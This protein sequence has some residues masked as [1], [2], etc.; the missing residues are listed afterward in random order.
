MKQHSTKII[1]III[2][3]AIIYLVCG[4]TYAVVRVLVQS[5][6]PYL[7][8]GTRYLIGGLLL[9]GVLRA[10]DR[11]RPSLRSWKGPLAAG[12]LYPWLGWLLSPMVAAAAMSLSSVTVILNALRLRNA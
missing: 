8:A 10:R 4:S 2:A 5:L 7:L 12:V 11:P 6:P 3:F 9:Y 1:W